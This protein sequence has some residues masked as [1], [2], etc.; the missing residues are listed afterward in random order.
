ME[1][2]GDRRKRGGEKER[3]RGREGERKGVQERKG[4]NVSKACVFIFSVF[5]AMPCSAVVQSNPEK[6]L[7]YFLSIIYAHLITCK[8]IFKL[9]TCYDDLDETLFSLQGQE[10]IF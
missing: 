5:T 4:R 6:P 1:R 8:K 7:L 2:R 9:N 3:G 10:R